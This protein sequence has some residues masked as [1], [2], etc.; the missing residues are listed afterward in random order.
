M[1]SWYEV[2]TRGMLGPDSADDMEINILNRKVVWGDRV[3]TYEADCLNVKPIWK[4]TGLGANSMGW[5]PLS[6][7]RPPGRLRS[8]RWSWARPRRRSFAA[9]SPWRITLPCTG[10]AYR[11]R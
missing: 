6:S 8:R 3:I 9:W 5:M 10:R 11:W 7:R 4:S 1:K 2:K